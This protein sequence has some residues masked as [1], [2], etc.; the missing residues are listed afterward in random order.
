[1]NIFGKKFHQFY[2]LFKLIFIAEKNYS[3]IHEFS[4]SIEKQKILRTVIQWLKM[5]RWTSSDPDPALRDSVWLKMCKWTFWLHE[6]LLILSLDLS[7][8]EKSLKKSQFSL[9]G[10]KVAKDFQ[11]SSHILALM[12]QIFTQF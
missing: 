2:F 9:T 3:F 5:C 12:F 10:S 6:L 1:M 11:N 4:F 8:D 7:Y